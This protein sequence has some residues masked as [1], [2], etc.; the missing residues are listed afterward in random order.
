MYIVKPEG[1]SQGKGIYLTRKIESLTAKKKVIVQRYLNRPYLVN[2]YKFDLRLYALVTWVDPLKIFF[3]NDGLARFATKKYTNGSINFNDKNN[4]FTHLT[5][6]S[7]VKGENPTQETLDHCKKTLE[8]VLHHLT[9]DGH[10]VEN[11][12]AQIHDIVVKTLISIQP[13]LLHTYNVLQ[14]RSKEHDMCFEVLGFDIFI[15]EGVKPWLI[16]VN[17][18]P[19][20]NQDTIVDKRWKQGLISIL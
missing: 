20:F 18:M 3:Y 17:H 5:N 6:Y 10:N 13:K 19:S 12:M 14:P 11:L 15:D 4:V 7:L 9:M 8:Y 16:E 1:G 2:G